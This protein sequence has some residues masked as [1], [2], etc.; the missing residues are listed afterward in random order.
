VIGAGAGW[1]VDAAE[2]LPGAIRLL[3]FEPEAACVT[4]MFERRTLRDL[5]EAG[6]LMVLTGPDFDG[7]ATAWRLLGR[8]AVDPPLLIHPVIAVANRTAAVA[9][10]NLART[11]IASARANETARRRFAAPYLLNTLR[12]APSLATESDAGALTGLYEG[13]PVVIAAAGPSLNRNIEELRPYRDR[14]VLVAVDTALRPFL[15]AGL[16]PDFVVSVDPAPANACHLAGLPPCDETAL[17]AEASVQRATLEAFAGRTFLF[18]VAEHHPW[19]WLHASGVDVGKLR[20]WG[21][22]LVTAFD[23]GVRLGGDPLIIVG[24][25]LA[26][27]DG[28]PYCR[29]TVYEEDWAV[30]VAGGEAL[31]D[32]WR[33]TISLHPAVVERHGDEAIA[34][35]PHLVHFR[36]G[37]LNA[38]RAARAK[39]INATGAGILRGGEVTLAPIDSVLRDAPRL[40]RK[41]LPRSVPAA[42]V[43]NTLRENTI[44]LV[45]RLEPP[46]EGWG[47]VLSEH[48]PPDSTLPDQCESVRVALAQWAGVGDG[49]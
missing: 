34:T 19:P 27:T 31:V 10:A 13:T 22:V 5:I 17:V 35:A 25:D 36:D 43:V 6:H 12:N 29:G 33:H 44:R 37:L 1:V 23:L 49:R 32:V 41:S 21:S 16:R 26:Y 28:Q 45:Q 42:A 4:A 14:A 40:T 20:A 18:R 2:E 7:A 8:I 11:V 48:E 38:A 24:A 9:A 47:H 46:N 30:K 15:A 39:V 3:V